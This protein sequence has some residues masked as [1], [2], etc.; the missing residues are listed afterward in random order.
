MDKV[1]INEKMLELSQKISYNFKNIDLLAA[2]QSFT[3][4]ET[5]YNA[6]QGKTAN[7]PNLYIYFEIVY[8]D[9]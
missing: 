5:E 9:Q 8:N 3:M 1:R 7:F 4:T 2:R 6:L